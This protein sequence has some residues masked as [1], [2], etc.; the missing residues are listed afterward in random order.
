MKTYIQLNPNDPML[1]LFM[2][3][4]QSVWNKN[5]QDIWPEILEQTELVLSPNAVKTREGICASHII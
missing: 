3:V 1:Q 4:I 5:F 2:C